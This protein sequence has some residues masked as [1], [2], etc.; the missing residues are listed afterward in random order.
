MYFIDN[1]Y[2]PSVT[3]ILSVIDKPALRIWYGK[4]IY[5]A[6]ALHPEISE[7]EA[8]AE[9]Y[10]QGVTAKDRGSAVHA[11]VEGWEVTGKVNGLDGEHKGYAQAFDRWIKSNDVKIVEHERTICSDKYGYAGT[12]DLLVKINGFELPTL[13]DIKTG[14]DIYPEAQ[15]QVSA[16]RVA[17]EEQGTKLDSTGILLLMEDGTY[18][19]ELGKDKFAGF[20]A[21]KTLW[22]TLNEDLM[23]KAGIRSDRI[24]DI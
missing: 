16:Y 6:V 21:C 11:I 23:I 4:Q 12:L 18:K 24:L 13:I 20:L 15:L 2:Y 10:K 8:L 1:K 5:Q 17:C 3:Q 7:K 22:E 14:K 19:F 9:P